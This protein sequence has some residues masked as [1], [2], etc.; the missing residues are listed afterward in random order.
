LRK[1]TYHSGSDFIAT[2]LRSTST[3]SY[4]D[5]A[6][7]AWV[8]NRE[9]GIRNYIYSLDTTVNPSTYET[10]DKPGYW[11]VHA[12]GEVW[13][14]M[15]WVVQQRLIGTYGFSETLLP[16]TPN[17]DGSLPSNDCYRPQTFNPLS[18]QANLEYG[19][20][21]SR[22]WMEPVVAFFLDFVTSLTCSSVLLRISISVCVFYI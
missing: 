22:C 19:E 13:A 21:A 2:S 11:G 7:G 18:G 9:C 15:L 12:I 1:L 20:W 5:Y 16:P 6:M 3:Y 8:S 17:A 10:L 4:S 14:E